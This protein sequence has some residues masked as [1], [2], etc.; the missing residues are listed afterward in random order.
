MAE[1]INY[2]EVPFSRP[3]YET[4]DP[5]QINKVETQESPNHSAG[6]IIK[7]SL[8]DTVMGSAIL[9][10][11]SIINA[12]EYMN[13][14][15]E[16][17]PTD[18]E[19]E[20]YEE[21]AEILLRQ[22]N[23]QR[24][25]IYKQEIDNR[26][27]NKKILSEGGWTAFTAETL[28]GFTDLPMM[29][30][31]VGIISAKLAK[32]GGNILTKGGFSIMKNAG[33]H[34]VTGATAM[35]AYEASMSV[36]DKDR[37]LEGSAWNISLGGLLGGVFGG[38]LGIA[39]NRK[40]LKMDAFEK[41]FNAAMTVPPEEFVSPHERINVTEEQLTKDIRNAGLG[42][43]GSSLKPKIE[44]A[45]G[46]EALEVSPGLRLD[47]SPYA[48]SRRWRAILSQTNMRYD[49]NKF[50][51][52]N[53]VSIENITRKKFYTELDRVQKII[54]EGFEKYAN[55]TKT[56]KVKRALTG[57]SKDY[58]DFN[59]LVGSAMYNFDKSENA[60]VQDV[61]QKLRPII[62]E[63]GNEAMKYDMFGMK[64]QQISSL[65]NKISN[66]QEELEKFKKP[67]EKRTGVLTRSI[68]QAEKQLEKA[69]ESENKLFQKVQGKQFTEKELVQFGKKTK[70]LELKQRAIEKENKKIQETLK[71]DAKK[72]SPEK[73]TELQKK[74]ESNKK[75]IEEIRGVG[76]DDLTKYYTSKAQR[77]LINEY[78]REIKTELKKA[79]LTDARRNVLEAQ[80]Q[81]N[82]KNYAKYSKEFQRAYSKIEDKKI[83]SKKDNQIYGKRI[84]ERVRKEQD[85]QRIKN[86]LEAFE[87]R[88]EKKVSLR[89][90]KIEELNKSLEDTQK[91]TFTIEDFGDRK[92]GESYFS[93]L[94]DKEAINKSPKRFIEMAKQGFIEKHGID[95]ES[96]LDA[97]Y[98]LKD[99]IL[100]TPTMRSTM[101]FVVLE[102]GAFKEK[103][104]T[105]PVS[106]L[107]DFVITNADS[108]MEKYLNTMITD[109]EIYKVFGDLEGKMMF[110]QLEAERL[111][112]LEAAKTEKEARFIEKQYNND[113]RDLQVIM[114]RLRGL[115]Q[116]NAGNIIRSD[117]VVSAMNIVRNLNNARLMG[118]VTLTA[119]AD[120][121][122]ASLTLG[123]KN[124]FGSAI[125]LFKDPKFFKK[126]KGGEEFLNAASI[127]SGSR[128]STLVDAVAVDGSMG[129]AERLS[130]KV[131]DFSMRMSGIHVW[132]D[133]L[134]FIAG[135]A[136][137]ER[138]LKNIETSINTGK[139][140]DAE[141]KWMNAL[142][143]D[144]K[145][146]QSIYDQFKKHGKLERGIYQPSVHKWD[147]IDAQTVFGAS[148]DKIQSS[149]I[150]TPTVG[151][152]PIMFDNPAW[153]MFIQFKSFAMAAFQK[154]LIPAAQM[155][156]FNVLTAMATMV[157]SQI[158]AGVI[159]AGLDGKEID[160]EKL[161]TDALKR[162]DIVA[163]IP[164]AYELLESTVGFDSSV[165]AAHN[166][167]LET[168]AGPFAGITRDVPQAMRLL[169]FSKP[170]TRTQLRSLR[171]LAPLQNHFIIGK[172]FDFTEDAV[173]KL[174]NIKS[175]RDKIGKKVT[176]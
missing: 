63:Y 147:N 3:F 27:N 94:Y 112:F 14:D 78:N 25:D 104:L 134:K 115:H 77:E 161:I 16:F 75:S 60:I 56:Q 118:R 155:R 10:L 107:D 9:R 20:G 66:L 45:F 12:D 158:F 35:G 130:K 153:K 138:I 159:R 48:T 105:I 95:E 114:N 124:F 126:F 61:A 87:K 135:Y 42:I 175:P 136:G 149:A 65:E 91:K 83:F 76:R 145:H 128:M 80:L 90:Q 176:F 156:D 110:D 108:V 93:T 70:E 88:E 116:L 174:F 24:F 169:N 111:E 137:N 163:F 121:G 18:E 1:P 37:T 154:S 67:R 44:D 2:T 30:L 4:L 81:K 99:K 148:I 132:D 8:Q 96:A 164:D 86:R 141:R 172:L 100:G 127:F 26:R 103:T 144:K 46:L 140:S 89:N 22:P 64:R 34:A 168:I 54:N 79:D 131:S 173:A 151:D 113:R 117:N 162:S 129:V 32:F 106:M 28:A 71:K 142:G 43:K 133:M 6:E 85:L 152:L 170:A 122:Q 143:I 5:Q 157:G 55:E 33:V 59:R 120:L 82:I 17:N 51:I 52:A 21:Y 72:L 47:N 7:A 123:F 31:P 165:N 146:Y 171:R 57:T 15:P 74:L 102:R 92:T 29:L 97:A 58:S 62:N 68:E 13:V 69:R 38:A 109:T 167:M 53:P 166:S 125:K 41:D 19:L 119:M 98:K 36:L 150:I 49:D 160:E 73:R 84:A 50:D 101:N 139:L 11:K 40:M 39:K 23:R